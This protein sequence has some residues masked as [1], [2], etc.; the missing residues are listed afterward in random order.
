MFLLHSCIL[1]ELAQCTTDDD[2][3]Q[4]FI[5]HA[6]DFEMYLQYITGQSQTKAC[7][8]DRNTQHFFKVRTHCLGVGVGL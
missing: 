4:C 7:I 3:A 8:S 2:V 6:P 1:P 5:N